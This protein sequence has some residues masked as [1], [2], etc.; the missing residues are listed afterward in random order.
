[1]KIGII[2]RIV[3]IISLLVI[4]SNFDYFKTGTLYNG[5]EKKICIPV[6]QCHSCPTSRFACPIGAIESMLANSVNGPI[7]PWYIIGFLGITMMLVGRAPCAWL[8]PFGFLQDLLAKISPKK[9]RIP[10][11]LKYLKYLV[12]LVFVIFLPISTGHNWF[13]RICPVG[14]LTAG[15]P[16]VS[17][18]FY[19]TI[20]LFFVIKV[21]ILVVVIG[22][23]IFITRFFCR[24]LCPLGAILGLFNRWSLFRIKVGDDCL[25]CGACVDSCPMGVKYEKT[26]SSPECIRCLKCC[27]CKHISIGI[28]PGK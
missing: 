4:N 26:F 2:Q 7:I 13:S 18:E 12:L 23:S 11:Y 8:C 6:L 10:E 28:G 16:W 9:L 20:G 14:T 1:M 5:N 17:T 3:Q 19:S 22:L 21:A 24:F 25:K 15:I 27:S